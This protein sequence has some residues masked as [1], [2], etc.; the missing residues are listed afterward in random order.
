M[1]LQHLHQRETDITLVA[2]VNFALFLVESLILVGNQNFIHRRR[3]VVLY[4][5]VQVVQRVCTCRGLIFRQ[6]EGVLCT[7]SI[8]FCVFLPR[9]LLSILPWYPIHWKEGII[10]TAFQIDYLPW[11][12]WNRFFAIQK[13]SISIYDPEKH[14]ACQ[15]RTL[16]SSDQ[17]Y[18][19]ISCNGFYTYI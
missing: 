18:N 16:L 19:S 3:S 6:H 7:C 12:H 5:H 14:I 4:F 9:A 17:F 8:T 1:M 10:E 15:S 13:M 11:L 2:R